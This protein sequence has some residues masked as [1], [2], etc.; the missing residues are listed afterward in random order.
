[1]ISCDRFRI[2]HVEAGRS[3]LA[4][5]QGLVQGIR[6]DDRATGDVHEVR[7]RLHTPQCR[8]VDETLRIIGQ[9]DTY[10]DMVATFE[11]LIKRDPRGTRLEFSGILG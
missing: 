3:N 11:K 1:M 6:I 4:R 9:R 2:Y 10:H 8:S 7:C 5:R